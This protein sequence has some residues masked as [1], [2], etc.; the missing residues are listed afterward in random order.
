VLDDVVISQIASVEELKRANSD[1]S[2]TQIFQKAM[3]IGIAHIGSMT[4][5]LFLA[6]AGASLP[7]L[8]VF[9]LKQEPFSTFTQILD[10]EM[11]AT[12]IVRAFVGSI[13]LALAVPI[14]TALAA[15]YLIVK[16]V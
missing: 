10:N 1:L 4:N 16:E 8:L 2:N 9:S 5:T 13:G 14:S 7:L 12:E 11:I 6:Y 15:K 3:K